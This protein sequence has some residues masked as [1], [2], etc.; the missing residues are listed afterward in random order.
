[1]YWQQHGGLAVFGYPISEDFQEVSQTDGQE[2]T[3]QYCERARL[4]WHPEN[5]GTPYEFLLG[6]LGR[7]LLID[8]GWLNA[9]A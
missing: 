8:R 2:H 3:V 4:E 7:E 6:H 1:A 5:Q 9:G